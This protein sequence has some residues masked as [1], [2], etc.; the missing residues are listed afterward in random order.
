MARTTAYKL[1]TSRLMDSLRPGGKIAENGITYERLAN[2]DGC[3][4]VNI[5]VDGQRIHRVV[6]LESTGTNKTQVEEYMSKIRTDAKHDRLDLPTGRKLSKMFASAAL[7][8]LNKLEEGGTGGK[9]IKMRQSHLLQHLVPSFKD[10]PLSKIS[11]F[12]IDRYKKSRIDTGVKKSTVNRELAVL[13]HMFTK[14]VDW[15]WIGK[16]PTKVPKYKED[17]VRKVYLTPEQAARIIDAAKEDQSPVIYPFVVIGLA[18][19][20]R[21]S[22]IFSIRKEHVNAAGRFITVPDAKAGNR[23]QPITG[24]LAEYLQGYIKS[25]PDESPWLFPAT[26]KSG[27]TMEIYKPFCRVVSTAGLDPNEIG[28]HSMRHTVITHAVQSGLD[29]KTI[30]RISGHKTVEMVLRY[31]HANEEHMQAAMDKLENRMKLPIA[32]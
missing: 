26:S 12:D 1:M 2:G 29:I 5:M 7:D 22:E 6:G 27:H 13:S 28:P 18:T 4:S 3:F 21:R 10:V 8:Y 14:A 25:L 31:T 16:A 19:G 30:Q 17:K 23:I 20:M 24:Q 9:D 11:S 15:K 32:G